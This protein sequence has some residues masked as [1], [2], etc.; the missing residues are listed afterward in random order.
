MVDTAQTD[1]TV[2]TRSDYE[3]APDE[4]VRHWLM[5][6]EAAG[7]EEEKWREKAQNTIDRYRAKDQGQRAFNIL[8]SNT[9]TTVPALYNSEPIP[10]VRR[11]YGDQDEDGKTVSQVIER[12]LTTHGEMYDFDGCMKAAVKDRQLP[13]RGVTRVRVIMGESGSKSFECEPVIWDDF[14][15]GPSK[16]WA[17]VP[18][19]AIRYKL[20]REELVALNKTIGAKVTLDAVM[21]DVEKD[22]KDK[23]DLPDMFKRATVWEVW[24]KATRRAFFIAESYTDGPI[25]VEQDPYRLR[26]F[27]PVPEPLYGVSTTDTLVP[28][29]Q[30]AIW[31]PL[32]DEI[33]SLT[34]RTIG[35]VK[36][37]KWRGI[38][39]GAFASAV[40]AMKNLGDGELAPAEDPQRMLGGADGGIDKRVW[41]M[42]V[43]QA[44]QVVQSLYEAREQA[45]VSLYELT[46]IADIMRGSTQANETLGAQQI[47]TQ[48]GSLRLQEGQRD[49]QRYA[50]DLFRILADLMVEML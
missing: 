27:Y 13:G 28:V 49:V 26:N 29:C 47:K 10:D 6:I 40:A 3:K 36:V 8:Y 35:L 9:Q 12:A 5:A 2:E 23:T 21:S 34:D 16:R 42:P 50:R 33:D 4:F 39:D 25:K 32:A 24:E 44:V 30:L 45:K 41:L 14:R 1:G 7:K 38:Y 11:R 48:W 46:G 31:E 20:T 15:H 17:D 19:I 43:E 37:M 18:W 22:K